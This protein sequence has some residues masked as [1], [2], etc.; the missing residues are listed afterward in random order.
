[1]TSSFINATTTQPSFVP[2]N[3]YASKWN[4]QY[5]DENSFYVSLKG[6]I[7]QTIL[8]LP[9]TTQL[10]VHAAIK[11]A[12]KVF[13]GNNPQIKSL[14]D[15]ELCEA[16]MR[17]LSDILIDSTMQRKLDLAWVLHILK[18]FSEV[19][20]QPIRIYKVKQST[21]YVAYGKDGLYAA[22]DGQH[23][24]IALYIICVYILGEDPSKFM[25]PTVITK[26]EKKAEIRDL[27]IGENSEESK[28]LL[29]KID[30]Y[31]QYV[32]GV[33][34][35]GANIQH[36]VEAEK[37]QQHLEQADIFVTHEKFHNVKES[38]AI[39]RMQEI[40][41]YNSDI[42][43]KFSLYAATVLQGKDRPIASQEIEIMCGWFDMAKTAGVDYTDEEIVDLAMHVDLL[44]NANFHESSEFWEKARTA[45]ENWWEKYYSGVAE[46]YRPSRMSFTKNWR[47]GGTFLWHQLKKTWEGRIPRSNLNTPFQP[48][49]KDL[50]NV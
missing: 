33:R 30:L 15:I 8:P 24:V 42:I 39:S 44:F 49:A 18:N 21:E 2:V 28:K 50:F 17:P 20:I 38:G 14:K 45:Y 4:N 23:T 22:W 7:D 29:E 10:G 26:A 5:N 6:R 41:S 25:I 12:C 16:V 27:F 37:K 43:R 32:Y 9:Y 46:E 11:N 1:M 13:E 35:D 47:N 31:M 34:V 36:W 40:N 48:S 19:K 3:S